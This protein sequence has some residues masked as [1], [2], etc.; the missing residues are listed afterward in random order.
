MQ[1]EGIQKLLAALASSCGSMRSELQDAQVDQNRTNGQ[2]ENALLEKDESHGQL[3]NV[4]KKYKRLKG[5]YDRALV[6]VSNQQ[7]QEQHHDAVLD[8]EQPSTELAESHI[9]LSSPKQQADPEARGPWEAAQHVQ[10]Q[11]SPNSHTLDRNSPQGPPV[12]PPETHS[13]AAVVGGEPPEIGAAQQQQFPLMAPTLDLPPGVQQQSLLANHSTAQADDNKA[14]TVQQ[15]G[16]I[17][18]AALEAQQ[19]PKIK[20]GPRAG[21]VSRRR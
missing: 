7:E 16:G 8:A 2:L 17:G 1:V 19:R 21:R 6:D 4:T 5:Q 15:D 13:S 12:H 3:E 18:E 14:A 20:R 9:V 11:R 10:Q